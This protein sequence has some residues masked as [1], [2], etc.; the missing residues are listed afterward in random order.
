MREGWVNSAIGNICCLNP[1]KPILDEDIEVTFLPMSAVEAESGVFH[2]NEVRPFSK[3]K[4]GYTGFID[5]DILFAKITPCME[6]GKVALVNNLLNSVGYGSTEFHVIRPSP[7]IE[8]K[9]LH[10]F[11]IQK[12]FRAIAKRNMTGSAGQLRVP[13]SFFQEYMLPLAPLPEQRAIVAKIEQLFSE[14]DKGIDNLKTARKKLDI[15]RQSVL[16][17]AF[18]G[19]L[20]RE[21]REQQTD[22]PTADELLE[23]IQQERQRHYE[24]Q[25][26]EWEEA[27]NTWGENGKAGKKPRKPGAAINLLDFTSNELSRLD[28]IPKCWAWVKLGS[29][30]QV[31]VGSTPSK[32]K[33]S[34]WDGGNICWVSSGEVSWSMITDTKQHITKEGLKNSSTTVHP[35]GTVILAMIGEGKTRGQ[36]AILKTPSCHNQNTAAIRVSEVNHSPN[37][38][39]QYLFLKYETNR[40][41]GSGNNQKAL[42]KSRVM[43]FSFPLCSLEEQI[44]IVTEIESRL[45]VCDKLTESIDTSLQQSEALR[46]SILKK[47]FE[48]GLLTDE[49]LTACRNE[50]DWCPAG[51]LLERV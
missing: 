39:Y 30:Y 6:N 41:I 50:P 18:E 35:P 45:S 4:K 13:K 10:N 38:L 24:Q 33:K 44:Q 31:F 28:E 21:W 19:E 8:G 43:D 2:P 36:A 11:V 22:L 20:T 46:Q 9:Y 23:Q 14:L 17:K 51:E 1:K 34:Y 29:I 48:G 32:T 42:N 49:E 47:A 16:K 12:S 5:G 3:V 40:R 7:A 27:V 26:K 15:Y 25:L 37:Y